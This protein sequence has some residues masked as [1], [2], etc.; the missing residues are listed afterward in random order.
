MVVMDS[1]EI[2]FSRFTPDSR[3]MDTVLC[4]DGAWS[5]GKYK[6]WRDLFHETA[7]I[8]AAL[9]SSP[10]AKWLLYAEDYWHFLV[11][12]IA[13]FQ[14]KKEVLLTANITPGNIA[15]ITGSEA[16]IISDQAIP[17][18]LQIGAILAAGG[19]PSGEIV[20]V[21]FNPVESVFVIFTSGSTGK[22]KAIPHRI[23]EFEV[24]IGL[25]QS[26]V[27][28]WHERKNIV[29]VNQHHIYGLIFSI[30]LP[31]TLGVPFRRKRIER[32]EEF[33][34]LDDVPYIIYTSPAFLKRTTE[35]GVNLSMK[36]PYIIVSGGFLLPETAEKTN[37]LFGFWPVD[38]YGSTEGS[39]IA[40]RQS[41]DGPEWRPFASLKVSANEA[42]C[43]MIHLPIPN[44]PPIPTGDL[45]ELLPDGRFILKGRADSVVKIEEKRISLTE[46][47]ERILESGMV[48]D[49]CVVPFEDRRQYLAAAIVLNGKAKAQ[50]EGKEKA[51]INT[52]WTNY[53]AKYFEGTV[54][55]KK[56]RYV[57]LLPQ[58]TQGK[59]PR[60]QVKALFS[61]D[62]ADE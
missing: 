49:A 19:A 30:I 42:G 36:E 43:L 5:D 59:K 21:P 56:F 15:E 47:E 48:D 18:A 7:L 23:V 27:D 26:W 50:F 1:K 24:N 8:R 35:S 25:P 53:L 44:V 11:A 38:I 9:A 61:Q 10:K 2:P 34:K 22:P 60:E 46:V 29:T 51:E 12:F 54:I 17:G 20:H 55:P 33:E 14:C 40:W 62:S 28:A 57:D 3:P 4:F 39:G 52:Y 41:K 32:P 37:S 13:L 16:G 6:T 31:F 58:D 45:V